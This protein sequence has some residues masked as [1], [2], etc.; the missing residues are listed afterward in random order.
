M[1]QIALIAAATLILNVTTVYAADVALP[2]TKAPPVAAAA[3]N[4]S[5]A[6]AGLHAGG[7]W[8]DRAFSDYP[9]V[10]GSLGFGG[11]P[12][13]FGAT[14]KPSGGLA[15]GQVGYNYQV[16]SWVLG[17]QGD[18]AW[19]GARGSVICN[20]VDPAVVFT[21]LTRCLSNADWLASVTGRV[22]Y[23]WNASLIYVKGGAA[24]TRETYGFDRANGLAADIPFFRGT[25]TNSGW[26]VGTGLEFG[27]TPN[28]SLF[29][30]Y[31]YY[32]FGRYTV[33][34]DNVFS[35]P[36]TTTLTV[37]ND[38]HTAKVGFNYRF[39]GGPIVAKY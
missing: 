20:P 11:N 1:K 12:A 29:A 34:F 26:T 2:Y 33:T 5:G 13:F 16:S 8:G 32:D 27:L 10:F 23:A 15:G 37:R 38:M 17:L 24:W 14:A 18:L 31:N 3:Y 4:W 7:T 19:N 30:E 6:Y 9:G 25:R 28:W 39:G 22:G 36:G 35:G 21:P